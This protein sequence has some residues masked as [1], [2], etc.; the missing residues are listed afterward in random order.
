MSPGYAHLLFASRRPPFAVRAFL[1]HT[2][3]S[4]TLAPSFS[5]SLRHDLLVV[6]FPPPFRH[7]RPDAGR[8]RCDMEAI[9]RCKRELVP[10]G[11]NARGT[12][13]WCNYSEPL[14]LTDM[15]SFYRDSNSFHRNRSH[16]TPPRLNEIKTT[17]GDIGKGVKEIIAGQKKLT[18]LWVHRT[19]LMGLV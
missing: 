18:A 9:R 7:G 11:H 2:R 15:L 5:R 12:N 19:L 8:P 4:S 6:Q 3:I 13:R 14:S 17:L 16:P 10:H 1:P